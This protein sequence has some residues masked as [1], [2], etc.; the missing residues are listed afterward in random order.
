MNLLKWLGTLSQFLR[1]TPMIGR[2]GSQRLEIIK[3]I[4]F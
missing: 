2:K 3:E 4:I 1:V